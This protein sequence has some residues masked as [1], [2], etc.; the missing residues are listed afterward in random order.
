[1]SV[2]GWT[3]HDD[4]TDRQ[5]KG[6]RVLRHVPTDVPSAAI[7]P[8]ASIRSRYRRLAYGRGRSRGSTRPDLGGRPAAATHDAAGLVIGGRVLVLGGGTAASVP[9]IQ[10]LAPGRRPRWPGR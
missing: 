6:P 3:G 4:L 9:T 1:M 2:N 7:D 8:N 5:D 10:A